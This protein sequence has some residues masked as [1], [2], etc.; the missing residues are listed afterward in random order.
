MYRP[1]KLKKKYVYMG[2]SSNFITG[3]KIS[4]SVAGGT[5]VHGLNGKPQAKTDPIGTVLSVP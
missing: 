4:C 5:P 1:V 2:K 3:V